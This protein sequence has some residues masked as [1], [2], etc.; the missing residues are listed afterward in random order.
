MAA[1]NPSETARL[2]A[3]FR[4]TR[5]FV[6]VLLAALCG[7]RRGEIAALRW[8]SIDLSRCEL[9]VLESAEQT[10]KGVR[11]KETKSGR[12]RTVALPTLVVEELRLARLRQAERTST[13]RRA[14]QRPKS[15]GGAVGRPASPAEQSDP[16]ICPIVR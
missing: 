9:S 13:R 4:G 11:F 14:T 6:P 5:M 2:L 8:A 12:A 7:L 16:R 3:H 10:A 1:L 15:Y